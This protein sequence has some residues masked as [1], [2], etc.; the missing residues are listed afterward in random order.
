MNRR[1]YLIAAALFCSPLAVCADAPP[2]YSIDNQTNPPA[3]VDGHQTIPDAMY[4]G[5]APPAL[6]DAV[7]SKE[8]DCSPQ[9][10]DYWGVALHMLKPRSPGEYARIQV[11]QVSLAAMHVHTGILFDYSCTDSVSYLSR[12]CGFRRGLETH[13]ANT[14]SLADHF[15]GGDVA[16]DYY[17]GGRACMSDFSDS[18]I[19]LRIS[20]GEYFAGSL[21]RA[22]RNTQVGVLLGGPA[23]LENTIIEVPPAIPGKPVPIGAWFC[24]VQDPETGR[25]LNGDGDVLHGGC[26]GV[27]SGSLGLYASCAGIKADLRIEGSGA[28]GT[29]AAIIEPPIGKDGKPIITI[30]RCEL[31]LAVKGC[32]GGVVI[33][34]IGYG[35]RCRFS[36]PNGQP[37]LHLPATWDATS[38]VIEWNGKILKPGDFAN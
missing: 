4:Q 16:G 8:A 1:L 23:S 15:Y 12:V 10:K 35:W 18:R 5:A 11:P 7:V 19:G 38:N 27:G 17:E 30:D 22:R 3:I 31:N 25:F 36:G 13:A 33:K 6:A 2:L 21:L 20:G 9:V 34:S 26:I 28:E 37:Q 14:K 24:F 32:P 29:T